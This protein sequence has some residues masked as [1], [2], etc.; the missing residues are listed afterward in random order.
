[1]PLARQQNE[2]HEIAK[3]IDERHDLGRQTAA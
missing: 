2:A 3:R 1:V